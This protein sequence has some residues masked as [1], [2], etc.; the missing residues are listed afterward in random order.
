MTDSKVLWCTV[1]SLV[2][3]AKEPTTFVTRDGATGGM[4]GT[5]ELDATRDLMPVPI[6]DGSNMVTGDPTTCEQAAG[7]RTY[8]GC[9]FWPTVLPN[10]VGT[11]FHY[12]VA[13]ANTGDTPAEITIER[14]G[15]TLVRSRAPA[16]DVAV[17][18]LPWVADLKVMMGRC[19][20]EHTRSLNDSA[21]VPQGAYHLVSSRPV[22]VY[23]FNPLEYQNN[24][25]ACLFG[26][27]SFSND[28]SLLLPS[29]AATGNYRITAMRGQNTDEH[30]DPGYI[31]VTGLQDNTRVRVRIGRNG[32]VVAGNG[33]AATMA[34]GMLTFTL[35]RGEVA[36]LLGTPDGDL[37]GS[38][39][40]A[41][42]PVQVLVGSP[43][44]YQ[45]F[46]RQSCDHIEESVFPAETLGRRYLV[47]RPTGPRGN[48]V[49]HVVRLYGN[50]NDTLLRWSGD[51][52]PR[53]PTQLQAG[54]VVDLGV[55]NSDFE[56]NGEREFGVATFMLGQTI[57]D[58]GLEGRGDPSQTNHASVEQYRTSYVFL[59]PTNYDVS[60]ADVVMP[61][62]ARVTLNGE[63]IVVRPTM[64]SAGW[65]IA[66]LPLSRM[67]NVHVLRSDVAVGLQVMGYGHAT[68]YHYPGGL[69]LQGIAPPPPP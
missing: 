18:T 67:R 45:P 39:V 15:M 24:E 19:D 29:T 40:Q 51:V 42:A 16:N 38:L 66:R 26:R 4:D 55:V 59:A 62:N 9:D 3:C 10:V 64:I 47:H 54:E 60:F 6:R 35:A 13:V 32:R 5:V 17:F 37:G 14:D 36:R 63:A 34:N 50:A 20:T 49:G 27:F 28:A 33:I 22:V 56:V 31:S 58:P 48:A 8:V 68:S 25:C 44:I 57:V 23:Q 7:S 69:N 53:A 43:C 30:R 11:C 1:L 21:K 46:D 41:D 12:A 65:G 2:A 61:L 52:P